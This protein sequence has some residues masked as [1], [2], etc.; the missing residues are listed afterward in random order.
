M[1]AAPYNIE[2]HIRNEALLSGIHSA[3]EFTSE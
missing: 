3:T 1:L 2:D